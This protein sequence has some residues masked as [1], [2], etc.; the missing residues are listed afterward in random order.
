MTNELCINGFSAVSEK[1]SFLINGG[2]DDTLS[3]LKQDAEAYGAIAAAV[4]AI[5]ACGYS[6]GKWIKSWF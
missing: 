1:E 5:Y 4:V 3:Q 2:G 6:L